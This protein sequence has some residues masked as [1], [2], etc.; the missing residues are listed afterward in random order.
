MMNL[1]LEEF[2]N[3]DST[4]LKNLLFVYFR[5]KR[6]YHCVTEIPLLYRDI[7]DFIAFSDNEIL[8]VEI[9]VDRQDFLND[10]K[11]KEKHIKNGETGYDKFYFCVPPSLISFSKNMLENYPNYGILSVKPYFVGRN[12]KYEIYSVK[13]AKVA[14]NA[15][16][17]KN[18]P[19]IMNKLYMRMSSELAQKRLENFKRKFYAN[20]KK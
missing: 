17:V 5:F 15:S 12:K 4:D 14:E 18:S 6:G 11:T 1:D 8:C 16:N 19:E 7:E 9:K 3:F 13:S 20:S 10:F 2:P